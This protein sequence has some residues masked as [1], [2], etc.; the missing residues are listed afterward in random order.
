ML[1]AGGKSAYVLGLTGGD[2]PEMKIYADTESFLIAK[3]SGLFPMGTGRSMTL[4][5]EFSDFRKVLGILLPYRINNYAGNQE[6]AEIVAEKYEINREIADAVFQPLNG[7]G[8][9]TK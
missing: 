3:V 5:L 6:I 7:K 2:G 4:S 8:A 1:E 9:G